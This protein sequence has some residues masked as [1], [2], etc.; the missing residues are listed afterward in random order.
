MRFVDM[1][2]YYNIKPIMV[3][4]GRNLP[5]KASTELKRRENRAKHRKMVRYISKTIRNLNY[6]LQQKFESP[7]IHKPCP[8]WFIKYSQAKDYLNEGKYREAVECFQK[9]IDI[10]P[11]MARDVIQACRDRNIDCIVAPYEGNA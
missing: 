3:F 2:L 8:S 5:S 4:D 6:Y 11:K 10:T 7:P 9:A 1:L